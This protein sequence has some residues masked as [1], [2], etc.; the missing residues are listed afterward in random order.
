MPRDEVLPFRPQTIAYP[1]R[2]VCLRVEYPLAVRVFVAGELDVATVP[3]LDRCLRQAAADAPLVLLDLRRVEFV[4]GC[5]AKLLLEADTRIRRAGGRLYVR[6]APE[7]LNRLLRLLGAA[8]SL[9]MGP[10]PKAADA[11]PTAMPAWPT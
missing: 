11:S 3:Q 2:F 9:D 10:L 5:G 8:D 7:E 1:P 6:H 4:A